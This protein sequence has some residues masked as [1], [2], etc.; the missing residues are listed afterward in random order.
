MRT[1]RNE[2]YQGMN[3]YVKNLVDEVDD[4]KLRNEFAAYGTIT[5]A[6]VM[7][8]AATGKSKGF[9]FVCFSSPEEATRAVTEVNSHMLLVSLHFSTPFANLMSSLWWDC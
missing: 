6:K 8:D 2:K 1:E 7:R 3:L 4:E 5:S 9:G